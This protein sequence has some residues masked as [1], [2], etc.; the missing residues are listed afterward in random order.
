MLQGDENDD[1]DIDNN[2]DS[3]S[4]GDCSYV[5]KDLLFEGSAARNLDNIKT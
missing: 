3:D 1:D 2:D 5:V 4:N